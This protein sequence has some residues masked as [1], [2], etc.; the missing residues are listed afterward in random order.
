VIGDLVVGL[1]GAF[2]GDWLLPRLGIHLGVGVV[3]LIINAFIGAVV[4]LLILRLLGGGFGR[5][6]WI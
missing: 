5:R 4:L 2:I 6:R 1:V 3:A